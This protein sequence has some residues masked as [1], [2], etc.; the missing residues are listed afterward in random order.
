MFVNHHT[1]TI[2]ES[3]IINEV[4]YLLTKKT[5][6]AKDQKIVST[7]GTTQTVFKILKPKR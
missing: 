2:K 1:S 6:K 4:C 3:K 5:I 7:F